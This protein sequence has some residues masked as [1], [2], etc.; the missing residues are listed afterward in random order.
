MSMY[1]AQRGI[2]RELPDTRNDGMWVVDL[3]DNPRCG[4]LYF[5]GHF[6]YQEWRERIKIGTELIVAPNKWTGGWHIKSV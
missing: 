4:P 3:P 5:P 6:V 2:V 1:V